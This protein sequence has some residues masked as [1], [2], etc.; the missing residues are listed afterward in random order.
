MKIMVRLQNLNSGFPV[1]LRKSLEN[2]H[3]SDHF[4]PLKL[5]RHYFL[6]QIQTFLHSS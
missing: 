5:F 3:P 4:Q 6:Q 1:L 2:S